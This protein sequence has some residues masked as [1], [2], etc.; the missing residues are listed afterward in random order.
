MIEFATTIISYYLYVMPPDMHYLY[1][2]LFICCTV[3]VSM[4]FTRA[5]DK[6]SI[7]RPSE[8]LISAR[9]LVSVMGAVSI[10]GMAQLVACIQTFSQDFY[11][12]VDIHTIE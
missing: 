1:W 3:T 2:D 10:Q 7:A 4:S 11:K 8:S 5:S 12:P 6:L 9:T